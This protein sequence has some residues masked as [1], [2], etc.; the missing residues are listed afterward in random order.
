MLLDLSHKRNDSSVSTRSFSMV[1]TSTENRTKNFEKE[2]ILTSVVIQFRRRTAATAFAFACA[3]ACAQLRLRSHCSVF[4]LIRFCRYPAP[5]HTAPFLYKNGE[6]NI[7]FCA[8]TLLTETDKNLSVFV[9][10]DRSHCSVF[11]KLH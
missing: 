3:F 10:Y 4:K 2:P 11:V 1:S 8:F 9:I 5:V 6:R 7:R